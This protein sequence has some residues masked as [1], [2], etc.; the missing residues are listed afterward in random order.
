MYVFEKWG[1]LFDEGRGR[2]FCGGATFVA[3]SQHPG[4]YGHCAPFVIALF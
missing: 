3:L 2:Y 1:L 4:P